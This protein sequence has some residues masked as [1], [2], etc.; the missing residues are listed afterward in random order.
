MVY[1][2]VS[3]AVKMTEDGEVPRVSFKLGANE[4]GNKWIINN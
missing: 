3:F 4:G 1:H 2:G